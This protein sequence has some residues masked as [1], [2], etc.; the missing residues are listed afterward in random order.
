MTASVIGTSLR[1]SGGEMTTPEPQPIQIVR[2][3]NDPADALCAEILRCEGYPWLA[4]QAPGE[5]DALP[6]ETALV[7]VAGTDLP[8]EA[9]DAL[10][11]A[12]ADGLSLIA[13]SPSPALAAAFGV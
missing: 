9:A 10:V 4:E 11:K 12:V 7:V 5:L 1:N 6:A 8:R 3:G 13:V 2:A